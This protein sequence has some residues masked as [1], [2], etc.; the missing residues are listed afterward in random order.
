MHAPD[1][2]VLDTGGEPQLRLTDGVSTDPWQA[3]NAE[4]HTEAELVVIANAKRTV[5][6]D[7]ILLMLNADEWL[8]MPWHVAPPYSAVLRLVPDD[9]LAPKD[10][11]PYFDHGRYLDI[12]SLPSFPNLLIGESAARQMLAQAGLD[13]EDFQSKME[14]GEQVALHTG[15]QVRL[16]YG[17]VYEDVSATSV[18][19]YIPGLDMENQGERILVAATYTGPPPQDEVVYPGADENASGVAIM[20]E[21]ARLM[22]D[23]ELIPRRTV[24]FAAFDEGGGNYSVDHL[25]LPTRPSD[26]WTSVIL[27]GLGAGE[28]RLARLEAGTGPARAF[29]QSARRFGVRTE[30]LDEWLF[31][32]ISNY[33]RLSYTEPV[34]NKSYQGLIVTRPGD[35]LSGTPADTLD[36]LDSK[37]L[38]EAGQA[39]AHFAMVLSQ[40]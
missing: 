21:T 3:F 5:M 28:Q 31:F 14:A 7:G 37:L 25:I 29:D 9:E 23:L 32:F 2:E 4:G 18:I 36:H 33:S 17:L 38:E 19:G 16:T 10:Q 12:E 40:R 24:V 13:L 8:E 34:V 35:D 11:L 26:V 20:L 1:L 30:G 6:E 27:H 39:V 22:H 15:L